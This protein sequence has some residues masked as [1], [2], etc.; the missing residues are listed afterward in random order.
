MYPAPIAPWGSEF[1]TGLLR[2]TL[3][4]GVT[5]ELRNARASELAGNG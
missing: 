4:L 3:M 1:K 5:L 2:Q